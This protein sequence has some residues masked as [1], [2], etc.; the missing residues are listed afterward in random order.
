[1]TETEE[2]MRAFHEE[3]WRQNTQHMLDLPE[4]W[5]I[6]YRVVHVDR[7]GPRHLIARFVRPGTDQI[8]AVNLDPERVG[9]PHSTV[10][11]A[12]YVVNEMGADASY[13]L[14]TGIARALGVSVDH[15]SRASF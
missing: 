3:S 9:H 8:I 6:Y 1:M 11:P 13:V 4:G 2:E 12:S 14:H 5:T 7:T 15:F 10:Q